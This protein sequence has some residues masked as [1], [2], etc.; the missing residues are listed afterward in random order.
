MLAAFQFTKQMQRKCVC[1]VAYNIL[2]LHSIGLSCFG[3]L[4]HK[5]IKYNNKTDKIVKTTQSN[6]IVLHIYST[7][8]STDST[9]CISSDLSK[10]PKQ[11]IER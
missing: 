3:F 4:T 1:M 5:L 9:R 8:V 10:N 2:C 6:T 7:V 11:K